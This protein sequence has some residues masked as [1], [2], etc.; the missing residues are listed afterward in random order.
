MAVM[1]RES[2]STNKHLNAVSRH[3]RLC[4]QAGAQALAEAILP[5]YE[6]LVGKQSAT[7][8]ASDAREAATL[9]RRGRE[10]RTATAP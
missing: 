9:S 1:L 2:D 5:P 7:K 10:G 6:A 3:M 4:R 8:A